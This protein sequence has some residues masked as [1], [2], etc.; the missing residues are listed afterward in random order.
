[1]SCL[2]APLLS[3][4]EGLGIEGEEVE[5]ISHLV[6]VTASQLAM[7]KELKALMEQFLQLKKQFMQGEEEKKVGFQMVQIA[8]KILNHL[9]QEHLQD[10]VSNAYLEELT[11][12]STL[13]KA[14]SP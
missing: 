1:M 8:R 10:L 6:E 7:Q 11:F 5:T 9:K 12:F 13:S 2:L 4:H 14:A 3:A